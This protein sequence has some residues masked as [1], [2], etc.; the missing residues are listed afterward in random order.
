MNKE[1]H[2]AWSSL[3]DDRGHQLQLSKN[4]KYLIVVVVEVVGGHI[5]EKE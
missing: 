1:I 5:D 3:R 2:W 4:K